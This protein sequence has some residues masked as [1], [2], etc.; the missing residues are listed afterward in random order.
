MPTFYHL[1]FRFFFSFC[2]VG[3]VEC[4][5]SSQG[6]V[7]CTI[8]VTGVFPVG[9]RGPRWSFSMIGSEG[10]YL[11]IANGQLRF[12]I[13]GLALLMEY[14]REI[15]IIQYSQN[16]IIKKIHKFCYNCADNFIEI[17]FMVSH[18][19]SKIIHYKKNPYCNF[20]ISIF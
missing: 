7:N 12:G 2:L 18:V 10:L 16:H 14:Y 1:F 20:K 6:E 19:Q 5:I 4:I 11:V 17:P 9:V 8:M 13:P 3:C 15:Q